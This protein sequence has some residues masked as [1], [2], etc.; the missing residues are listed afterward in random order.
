[1]KATPPKPTLP[2]VY[3][4]KKVVPVEDATVGI[5][6]H[7]L[8]YGMTCFAGIRGY[9]RD[10]KLHVFRLRDHHE[11]LM[12]SSR[13]LG[14]GYYISYEDFEAIFTELIAK[15]AP[16]GDVYFRPFIF[17]P[18]QRLA[19]RLPGLDFDLAIYLVE[20][21]NY[22][23]LSKGLKLAIS[24]WRK[25]S[26]NAMPTKAKAGGC[27][28]NSSMA[29]T[30]AIRNGYHDAL[31]TDDQGYVVEGSVS[32]MVMIYRDQPVI[33]PVG[34]A[35]LEGI[36]LRTVVDFF[37]EEGI[38]P[39]FQNVDRSMIYTCQ[40]LLMVGTAVQINFVHSVDGR[41]IGPIHEVQGDKELGP[42]KFCLLLRDKFA[43]VLA[44]TH[45]RSDEWLTAFKLR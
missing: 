16:E 40:E 11:R 6:C 7:S 4:D 26:D 33:P 41:K 5:A 44:G 19:P 28:V 45:P 43:S 31:L 35:Q 8:Q 17:S 22:F 15:N 36:T 32:N 29:T 39:I 18:T 34:S 21:D 14:M 2:Y 9:H 25:F 23:D 27:Y 30:D 38:E 42:G 1:M 37:R 20:L 12:N 24:G 10:G 13:I 3:F